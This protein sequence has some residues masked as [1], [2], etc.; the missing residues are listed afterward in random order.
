MNGKGGCNAMG[1][2]IR[3]IQRRMRPPCVVC[4][5]PTRFVNQDEGFKCTNPR[6]RTIRRWMKEKE[7]E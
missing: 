4:G 1:S 3:K 2:L 7:D 5:R 6:C